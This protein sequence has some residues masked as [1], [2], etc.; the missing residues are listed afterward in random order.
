MSCAV[1]PGVAISVTDQNEAPTITSS[2]GG[3]AA[4]VGVNENSTAVT[5]VTATDPDIPAQTL[6]YSVLTGAGSPDGAKFTIDGS[7]HLS[8]ISA[9]NFEAPGSAAGS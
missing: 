4:S 5:T 6:T 8:F 9:P 7:G 2:G 3:D 1:W